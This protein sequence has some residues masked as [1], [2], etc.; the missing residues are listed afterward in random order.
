MARFKNIKNIKQYNYLLMNQ[1]GLLELVYSQ[2]DEFG[3]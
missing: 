2:K 3:K 1:Y